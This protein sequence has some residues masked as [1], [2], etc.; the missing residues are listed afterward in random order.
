MKVITA[1]TKNDFLRS[2]DKKETDLKLKYNRI[3][4]VNVVCFTKSRKNI[5]NVQVLVLKRNKKKGGFWQTIT[6]GVHV[7]E[8]LRDAAKR[9]V[10]EEIGLSDEIYLFPTTLSYSFMGDDG[11][12]LKEYV[13][14]CEISDT[15]KMKIS[16]EHD[17]F[18]WM[19]PQEAKERVFYDNN[20][21]AIDAVMNNGYPD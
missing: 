3:A 13:F 12:M 16:D 18:E 10:F 1:I 17:S 20:K 21:Q 4:Q 15:S 9:E 8:D 5:D 7:G 14:G 11:Y 19:C 2:A 6:G